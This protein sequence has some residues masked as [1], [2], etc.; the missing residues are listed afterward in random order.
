MHN[1]PTLIERRDRFHCLFRLSFFTASMLPISASPACALIIPTFVCI[2]DLSATSQTHSRSECELISILEKPE[3]SQTCFRVRQIRTVPPTNKLRAYTGQPTPWEAVHT[4]RTSWSF[5]PFRRTM[6]RSTRSADAFRTSRSR[7][8]KR[9]VS[10]L[11]LKA[12]RGN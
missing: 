9:R 8:S 1:I 2:I 7:T 4:K 10:S 3:E 5:S 12:R 6:H 11:R